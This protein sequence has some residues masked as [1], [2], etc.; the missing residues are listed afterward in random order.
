MV[1]SYPTEPTK[2]RPA[3]KALVQDWPIII[4]V[5]QMCAEDRSLKKPTKT[6]IRCSRS[7]AQELQEVQIPPDTRNDEP[8]TLIFTGEKCVD[9]MLS[10]FR[11]SFRP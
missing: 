9:L 8:S 10:K 11:S 1:G 5:G 2:L 6:N 7:H 4:L 3:L